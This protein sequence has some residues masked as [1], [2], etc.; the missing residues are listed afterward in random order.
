[1]IVIWILLTLLVL[2]MGAITCLCIYH[3]ETGVLEMFRL[4][5]TDIPDQQARQDHRDH[6]DQQELQAPRDH[7]EQ[8]A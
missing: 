2:G 6:R 5:T 8:V 1:M 4:S 7:L 3:Q